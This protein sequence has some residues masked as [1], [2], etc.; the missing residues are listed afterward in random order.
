MI[1]TMLHKRAS[2]NSIFGISYKIV[3]SMLFSFFIQLCIAANTTVLALDT[4]PA[5]E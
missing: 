2:S 1:K 4:Y 5:I 3:N